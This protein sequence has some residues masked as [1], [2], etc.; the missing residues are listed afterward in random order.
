MSTITSHGIEGFLREKQIIPGIIPVSRAKWWAGVKSGEFPAPL[1]LS[2]RTT[3]WR[4]ADIRALVE[5]LGA[6]V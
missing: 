4:V 6:G 1:R 2:Q 5:K 3:V